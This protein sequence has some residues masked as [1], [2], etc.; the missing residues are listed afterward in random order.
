MACSFGWLFVAPL[1]LLI[2]GVDWLVNGIWPVSV[3]QDW[4]Y[5]EPATGWVGLD[6]IL[7]WYQTSL[8]LPFAIFF[9]SLV[10]CGGSG[11]VIRRYYK[12]NR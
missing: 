11:F 3:L 4:V 12:R 7:F 8:P 9:S 1:N 5:L 6:K 10:V 2:H